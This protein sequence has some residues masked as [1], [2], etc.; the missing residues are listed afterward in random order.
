MN[1]VSRI[2]QYN[3]STGT[4]VLVSEEALEGVE[5]AV[6]HGLGEIMFRGKAQPVNIFELQGM[7]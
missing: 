6:V 5:G 1:T 3:K 2:Q 7:E 4:R